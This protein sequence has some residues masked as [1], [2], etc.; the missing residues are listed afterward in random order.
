MYT[1]VIVDMQS[2]FGV[3]PES[4]ITKNIQREIHVAMAD[5]ASI[6]F[7]EFSYTGPT[8]VSLVEITKQANYKNTYVIE[9]HTNDGSKEI[10]DLVTEKSLPNKH[11]KVT[12][13]NTDYCV[14]ETVR[15][16]SKCFDT[17]VI[18]VIED[19]CASNYNHKHGID[20]MREISRVLIKENQ[21]A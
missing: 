21:A 7:V 12:G 18:E 19:A 10:F 11:F 3:L 2:A 16:M 13:V 9:K 1:L 4:M 17:S 14:F 20:K 6:V 5:G 8:L 15:G